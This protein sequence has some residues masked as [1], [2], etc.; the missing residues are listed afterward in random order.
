MLQSLYQTTLVQ[1]PCTG[2]H[3]KST[4]H[5]VNCCRRRGLFRGL[6]YD[7]DQIAPKILFLMLCYSPLLNSP[8]QANDNINMASYLHQA[9]REEAV[10]EISN[11][12]QRQLVSSMLN[13]QFRGTLENTMMVRSNT[14]SASMYLFKPEVIFDMVCLVE[15]SS[16]L[17]CY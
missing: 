8:Q 10:F 13:S 4:G 7:L 15:R 12:V 9:H 16:T 11:L 17:D 1:E 3:S 2:H 14:V 5:H 6:H